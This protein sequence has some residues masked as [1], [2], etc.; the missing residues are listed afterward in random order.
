MSDTKVT[1]LDELVGPA[2]D[3]DMLYLADVSD[4]TM[5][6]TGTSK[7]NQAKNY[8]RTNGTAN[9]LGANI[10]ANG[11]SFTGAGSV[12]S[13]AVYAGTI[14]NFYLSHFNSD[15]LINFDINDFI[16][17]NR[18][19][20]AFQLYIA[21]VNRFIVSD[22]GVVVPGS[23]TQGT[24]GY[25][26]VRFGVLGTPR[27]VFEAGG[28]VW[29]IDNDGA[30][31]RWFTPGVVRMSL[32]PTG[33]LD[34]S[35]NLIVSGSRI[36]ETWS[37]VSFNTGWA[38]LG[39]SWQTAQYKKVGDL[40]LLRGL[41]TRSSGSNTVIFTLPSGYRPAANT[42]TPTVSDSG[43]GVAEITTAGNVSFGGVGGVG[44]ISLN[45]VVF[46]TT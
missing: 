35:G 19:G 30:N 37:N 40:V 44:Y 43:F 26:N 32:S 23:V 42:L 20:N 5:A 14:S 25:N 38:N 13:A 33:D 36:G 6:A 16:T 46:S 41:V 7:K 11:Y 27:V 29:Q 3:D 34:V 22:D 2:A 9:T 12:S 21:A 28:T 31:F 1:V 17:Y 18:S 4:T 39:G 8:L 10:A 24:L 45:N 15:P